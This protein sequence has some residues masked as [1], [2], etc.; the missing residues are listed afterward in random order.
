MSPLVSVCIPV[1]NAAPYLAETFASVLRQTYANWEMVIVENCSSDGSRMLIERLVAEANDPRI[2]VYVNE[3]HLD[4]AGNMN[5]ALSLAR[6]EYVK[7][8]CADDTIVP[9]CLARQ[10]EALQ[11]HTSAVIAGCS[12]NITAPDGRTL[13]VR[14]SFPHSGVYKGRTVIDQCIRSAT[15][16]IGE[17]TSVLLRSSVLKAEQPLSEHGRYWI[18]FELWSRLLLHGDMFYDKE[19]LA[20]FR[21]HAG[22]ATRTFQRA[23]V[24]DFLAIVDRISE[25]TGSRLNALQRAWVHV[26]I[27]LMHI[28]RRMLY[29][30]V[31]SAK[32][33]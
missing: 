13:L 30:R 29:R 18:D 28:A 12:R 24:D 3:T 20:Q 27:R 32:P 8:L 1:Y 2:R 22:A 7:L 10:V 26:K 11:Q 21:L 9:H 33:S 25:V 15:N 6:G 5:R 19:P 14:S 4:M 16:L 17:P 31:A 23:T